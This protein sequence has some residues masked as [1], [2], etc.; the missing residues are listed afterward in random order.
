M[1]QLHKEHEVIVVTIELSPG[2]WDLN[3]AVIW[4]QA[5]VT[6]SRQCIIRRVFDTRWEA[7]T[8]GFT[9]MKNWIDAGKPDLPIPPNESSVGKTA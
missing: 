2:K 1:I 5:R 4:T 3:L 7:E 8:Y 9:L 6:H